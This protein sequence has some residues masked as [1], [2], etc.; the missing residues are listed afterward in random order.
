[1]Q[2]LLLLQTARTSGGLK[3]NNQKNFKL[4]KTVK[5]HLQKQIRSA[6]NLLST[7]V[8]ICG[9]SQISNAQV[10][11]VSFS[12]SP[13]GDY[14]IFEDNAGLKPGYAVGGMLGLGLGQYVEVHASYLFGDRYR[15]DFTR[16]R[17]GDE[18]VS[19]RLGLLNNYDVTIQR[20]GLAAKVNLASTAIV[21]YLTAGTGVIRM[22]RN[23]LNS[24]ESIYISGGAGLMAS[25]ASRFTFFIQASHMGY[26]YN[27][28]SAFLRG[29]EMNPARLQPANFTQVDVTNWDL[30]LGLRAYLG[31]SRFDN[32][33]DDLIFL[34]EFNGGWSNVRYTFDA[35][36][37]QIFFDESLGFPSTTHITGL[38]AGLDFGPHVGVRGFYWRGIDD[39]DG[40]DF[41]KLHMFGALFR[42]AFF[43]SGVTPYIN[44]GGGYM[45][46]MSD[47]DPGMLTNPKSQMFALTGVGVE[48]NIT[49]SVVLKGDIS[50]MALTEDGIDNST[51][52]SSINLSP[53]FTLGVSY[54]IGDFA[55]K[56]PRDRRQPVTEMTRPVSL[57]ETDPI[58]RDLEQRQRMQIM[59]ETALSTEIA[60]ALAAGDTLV[61]TNLSSELERLRSDVPRPV[62][63]STE[64]VI[65][66][67]KVVE[68]KIDDRTITLPVLEDGEIY[69]R[70]GKPAPVAPVT[71]G[72]TGESQTVRDLERRVEQLLREREA[73]RTGQPQ[74]QSSV[75]VIPSQGD[76]AMDRRMRQFEERMIA[77]L[78]SRQPQ[79]GVTTQP[80]QETTP[81]VTVIQDRPT[82][83]LNGIA[84]YLGVA[85]PNQG[86]IGL[87]GDYGSFLSGRIELIPE[88]VLGFGNDTRMYNINALM[89]APLPGI[90]Y[91]DPFLPYAG[92][93][94]GLMAF[95]NPPDDI[96]GIQFTW[97]FHLGAERDLGPGKL[98]I[99]YA[100][101]NLF[102]FNRINVGYRHTF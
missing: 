42:T 71:P 74:P 20:Y 84:A 37:G 51:S 28:G 31:G 72:V 70:F 17:G 69:I 54:R 78:E 32:S 80:T 40:L 65:D 44:V 81:G 63:E 1:L 10:S 83:E 8:V 68:K 27:P 100:N 60:K 11:G 95:S 56:R 62:D 12:L 102:S 88:F 45:R 7:L 16:L 59:R 24:S 39:R 2:S 47:Y 18:V 79:T 5:T 14:L 87:R 15:T 67:E 93:G 25:V 97:S 9:L 46:V 89:L 101:L 49:R 33:G 35:F 21:P 30:M 99:E 66:T 38:Q 92:L 13:G 75:T 22:G 34:D 90:R 98:F 85:N 91:I 6:I 41:D 3:G 4:S 36:Y 29:S 61:A 52:P 26:R 23:N 43:R 19:E 64:R 96:A 77:L 55:V 53:M 94:L 76:D 86:V 50:A 57:T 82:G 48:A 73:A 58:T